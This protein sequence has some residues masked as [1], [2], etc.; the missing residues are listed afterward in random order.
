MKPA[1]PV[2][3]IFRF[4]F[5]FGM[6]FK[7]VYSDYIPTLEMSVFMVRRT[8]RRSRLKERWVM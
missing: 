4:W 7:A 3:R 1:L 6:S 8:M 5:F 2:T